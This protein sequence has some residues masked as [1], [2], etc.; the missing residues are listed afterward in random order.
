V[1][2]FDDGPGW[3]A[4]PQV[5]VAL[6]RLGVKA[7]FFLLGAEVARAPELARRIADEGH[8]LGLHGFA[9]SR[10]DE[11]SANQARED[12]ERGARSIETATGVRPR[13]FR[14]PYGRLSVS[15][16][17]VC[18]SMGFEIVYWSAWGLDWEDIRF[19]AISAEVESSLEPG[20]IVLLH[21][22]ARFGRRRSA[23]PTARALPAI[24]HHGR[25]LG[26]AW[27]T[28]AG[29]SKAGSGRGS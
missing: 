26:L 4:T 29:D 28:L 25:E 23:L 21:D 14:P 8:E 13:W 5:L 16:H 6:G 18:L 20:A 17:E 2:T 24:V 12:L 9:H 11:L 15:S 22:N 1:L 3:D 7:T 27:T 19:D 10:F